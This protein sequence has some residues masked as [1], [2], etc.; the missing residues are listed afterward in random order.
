MTQQIKLFAREAEERKGPALVGLA[1]AAVLAA[2]LVAYWQM[3]SSQADLLEKRV[4]Q[5]NQQVATEKA[6]LD[7]MK[8]ALAQRTDPARLASE[9]AALKSRAAEAQEVMNQL[10]SG[11]LGT[12]EGYSNHL[13]KFARIGEPGVWLTGAKISNAGR[14]VEVQGRS[15]QS[16][17]VLKYAGE[18]N[19]QF[20]PLGASVSLVEMT[21]V[22]SADKERAAVAFK[23]F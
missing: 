7:E 8:K 4:A 10:R 14:A 22:V 23:L 12:L 20:A 1:L 2:L 15:L 19:R 13:I 16:E 6:A 21:P 11:Q 17:S 18:L 9:L 3:L 5:L